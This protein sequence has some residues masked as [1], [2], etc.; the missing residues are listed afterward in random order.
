GGG[1]EP[2]RELRRQP[3]Q[4]VFLLPVLVEVG[5]P[6]QSLGGGGEQQ[7]AEGRIEGR[8]RDVEQPGGRGRGRDLRKHGIRP[9]LRVGQRSLE[10]VHVCHRLYSI[11]SRLRPSWTFRR[12][13]SS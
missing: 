10:R 5:K 13:A 8:I 1:E 2:R 4:H 11:R 7:R 3:R 6:H 12:A 9:G